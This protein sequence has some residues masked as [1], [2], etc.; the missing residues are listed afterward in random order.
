MADEQITVEWIATAQ[1]MLTTIQKVDA[2]LDKQEKAMQKLAN[3][4]K[5]GADAAAGSFNKLEQELKENEA[6]LKAMAMGTKEFAEQKIKVDQLRASLNRV[7]GELNQIKTQEATFGEMARAIAVPTAA[8]LALVAA[9]IKV[10]D[11]Q[12]TIVNGGAAM[13]VNLD[14]LARKFQIQADLNDAQRVEATKAIIQESSA[15]GVKA[16]QGFQT[17][18]ALASTGF[19]DPLQSGAL[20]IALEGMQGTSFAG[21]PEQYVESTAQA[22]SAY[23]LDKTPKNLADMNTRLAGI[24]KETAVQAVDMTDFAKNAS[25][26]EKRMSIEEAFAGFAALREKG[27]A[28]S[29][30]HSMKQVTLGMIAP[31]V[32]SEKA[33]KELGL[34]ITDLDMVGESF[35]DAVAVLKTAVDKMPEERQ[36]PVLRKM[37]GQEGIAAAMNVMEALPRIKELEGVQN[38]PAALVN[39]V[40]TATG[41]M[42]A[43]VNRT[44]NAT[45]LESIPNAVKIA[46]LADRIKVAEDRNQRAVEKAATSDIP[47]LGPAAQVAATLDN[48]VGVMTRPEIGSGLG[49]ALSATL[50]GWF[51][52]NDDNQ[53][54]QIRLQREANE[55][56]RANAQRPAA[57]QRAGLPAARPREAP[58]PGALQP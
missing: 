21:S 26:L 43:Q 37:F 50:G 33:I 49:D 5:K 4:S 57:P 8:A 14:T 34:K 29:A 28:E 35:S 53:A 41:G 11:A 24:F 45:L 22:L 42:Q 46:D 2:R 16:E 20:K 52:K 3:T 40:A 30:S 23:G 56:A 19:K 12:R 15:A 7:K 38:N 32:E 17:A 39:N 9:L 54:E 31:N 10:A 44:E 47:G 27:T 6:A 55:L 36:A 1:Q 18:T 58:L 51:K 48:A 13:A 25:V